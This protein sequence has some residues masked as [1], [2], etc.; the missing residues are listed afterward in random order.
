MATGEVLGYLFEG[1]YNSWYVMSKLLSFYED[2]HVCV[3]NDYELGYAQSLPFGGF[4]SYK[5]GNPL[6]LVNL[7][8]SSSGIANSNHKMFGKL[9][10]TKTIGHTDAP[11]GSYPQH[12]ASI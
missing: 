4:E 12:L 9:K 1:L 7:S 2:T 11:R 3:S 10:L 6:A 8:S 5:A